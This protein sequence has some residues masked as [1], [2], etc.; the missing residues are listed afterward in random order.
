MESTQF[1]PY[2]LFLIVLAL[3]SFS[4][5]MSEWI[6]SILVSFNFKLEEKAIKVTWEPL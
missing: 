4:V 6:T 2:V 1:F 3:P 5:F